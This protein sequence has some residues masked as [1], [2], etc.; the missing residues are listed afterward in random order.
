MAK[1]VAK[2]ARNATRVIPSNFETV[3]GSSVLVGRVV[4][5]VST[6]EEEMVPLE[7]RVADAVT[8]SVAESED[9]SDDA[10]DDANDDV[11]DA[12]S[13]ILS[14]LIS[15]NVCSV[16]HTKYVGSEVS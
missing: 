3:W 2:A 7:L 8:E 11:S 14:V 5:D 9:A 10:S 13:D 12:V 15:S 16:I 6:L 1:P 4:G